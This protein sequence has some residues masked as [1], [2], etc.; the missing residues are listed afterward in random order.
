MS[1][2]SGNGLYRI[3]AEVRDEIAAEILKETIENNDDCTL[4]AFEEGSR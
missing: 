3:E 2:K 1:G 4:T